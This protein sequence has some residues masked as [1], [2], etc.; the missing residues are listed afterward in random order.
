MNRRSA[1]LSRALRSYCFA[2]LLLAGLTVTSTQ[3]H[4]GEISLTPV[5]DNTLYENPTGALSNGSGNHF[6]AGTTSQATN[7]LRRGLVAFDLSGVPANATIQ[8]VT[9]TLRMTQTIASDQ[10]VQ[11][12]RLLADWGEAGSDAPGQEGGGATAQSGDATWIHTFSDTQ[13]WATA[14]GDFVAT[15]S[16]T[17]TV[18]AF[19]FYDWQGPDLVADVEGWIA[20]PTTNFGWCVVGNETSSETAKRFDSRNQTNPL[21]RPQLTID[22]TVPELF[23]RGDCNDDGAYDIADAIALV[24]YLFP[25]STPTT[26]TC[27]DACD[28]NDDEALDAADPITLLNTLFGT[29]PTPLPAPTACGLDPAGDLLDCSPASNCP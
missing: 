15:P 6:F 23:Q 16:A 9:L 28:A 19:G 26:L 7:A 14:G 22:F 3:A 11:L 8:G 4:G 1:R 24:C 29:S 27:E 18:G 21:F 10:N 25:V 12:H 17:Q 20:D 5:R 2:A 13:F